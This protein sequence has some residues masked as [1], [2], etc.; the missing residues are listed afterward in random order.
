MP[1][2]YRQRYELNMSKLVK[3][4][5]NII[6]TMSLV[7]NYKK[8]YAYIEYIYKTIVYTKSVVKFWFNPR[9]NGNGTK[10]M[11]NRKN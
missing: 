11:Y 5:K 2:P 10:I 8:K 3:Y 4:T 9:T 7:T 6:F 1:W